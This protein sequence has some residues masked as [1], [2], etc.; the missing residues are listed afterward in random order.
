MQ[1]KEFVALVDQ[2]ELYQR[3]N[4]TMYRLRVALLA[5]LGYLL[6]F[7]VVFGVLLFIAVVILLRLVNILVI[8]I[9]ILFLGA[10]FIILRSLWI[11][12]PEPDGHELNPEDAPGLFALVDEV[13]VAT[14]GPT[15]CKILLTG[16]YNAG[17]VQRPRLGVFGW[18]ENYLRVGLPLLRALSLNDVRAVLAHEFGHLS[19]SHGKFT[20]WIYRVRQTWTQVLANIKQHPRYGLEVFERFFNW[21]APYFNAYTFVL[22]RAQ[23]YEADSCSVA[24]SGKEDAARALINLELKGRALSEDFWPA[25]YNR[26]D[27]ESQAPRD[28]FASMLQSL[29]EPIAP[30]KA[31]SWFSDL[32][33]AKHRY[34]DTHPALA[35]R[36]AAMG[37][38]NVRQTSDLSSFAITNGQPHA[39]E[40]LFARTPNAFIE[41]QNKWWR[42][43]LADGWKG[44]HEFVVE[45]E[46][47][48]AALDEKAKSG[49]LTV[50][51]LW[52]RARYV[53]GT[54]GHA[55]AI[56]LLHEVIALQPDH[57]AANYV[58]GEALLS[59]G[60]EAGIKHIEAA[61]EKEVTAVPNGCKLIYDFLI[62]RERGEEAE[63]YRQA[64]ANYYHELELAQNERKNITI[65][66]DFKAHGLTAEALEA[67]QVQLEEIP[68]L[69]SAYLVRKVCQHLPDAPSF[70]LGVTSKRVLRLQLDGRDKKLVKALASTVKYP[71]YT[72]IIALEHKQRPLLA[73]FRKVEGAQ[74]Y[75]AS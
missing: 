3:Q 40:S 70:V 71:G 2:L 57:A 48:L 17:I 67:L 7:G 46:Q 34:D 60:E 35:D 36:L 8:Q 75:R 33:T 65:R 61:M 1:E 37:Y 14:G 20:G 26:A 22:A 24:V 63:R 6:L 44:R 31:Q 4:P 47:G 62:A 58:L 21:Y 29:R 25:F 53:G 42:D 41:R 16:E 38:S 68:L 18:H 27:K 19:G 49:D 59:H 51:E 32:L 9:L 13:R 52:D 66:D 50:D 72:Y 73:M 5:A 69:R 28:T 43:E 56:P 55:A 15:L 74:I 23:E 12:F 10:A 54:E 39:D 45:A 11:K 30:D 64:A